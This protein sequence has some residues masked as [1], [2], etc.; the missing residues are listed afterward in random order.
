MMSD[1]GKYRLSNPPAGV[2]DETDAPRGIEARGC[3]DE[4]HVPFIDELVQR[5]PGARILLRQRNDKPE[6]GFDQ[7]AEGFLVSLL[8]ARTKILLFLGRQLRKA[9]DVL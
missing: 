2:G 9:G 5:V 6:V 4:P 7:L 8:N 3:L 1:R